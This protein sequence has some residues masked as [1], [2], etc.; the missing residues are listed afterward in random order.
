M[1]FGAGWVTQTWVKEVLEITNGKEICLCSWW[2]PIILTPP[3][4]I[5]SS[6]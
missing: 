1:L 2:S 5:M 3:S 4:G 6:R